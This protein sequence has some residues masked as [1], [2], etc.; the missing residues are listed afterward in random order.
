MVYARNSDIADSSTAYSGDKFAALGEFGFTNF[1]GFATDGKPWFTVEDSCVRQGRIL[2]SGS[3]IKNKASWF[4][5][6][7]STDDLLD[8]NR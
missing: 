2:V 5:G 7:F 8:P 3:N 4:T 1:L 6:L